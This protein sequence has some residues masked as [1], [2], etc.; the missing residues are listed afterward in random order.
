MC[1]QGLPWIEEHQTLC[2]TN[3]GWAYCVSNLSMFWDFQSTRVLPYLF[4]KSRSHCFFLGDLFSYILHRSLLL[5]NFLICLFILTCNMLAD[6]NATLCPQVMLCT[7]CVRAWE[8]LTMSC[9]VGIP[10]LLIPVHGSMLRVTMITVLSE[11]KLLKKL[12][13][14]HFKVLKVCAILF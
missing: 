14:V 12:S 7:A 9:R 13:F 8:M 4:R 5:M 11:C 1:P 3:N 6:D 10:L 2:N